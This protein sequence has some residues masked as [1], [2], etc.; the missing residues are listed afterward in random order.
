MVV[1]TLHTGA[2]ESRFGFTASGALGKAVVRN[3]VKRRLREAVRSLPVASGWDIVMNAR[4]KAVQADYHSLHAEL[5][6]LLT[7]ARVLEERAGP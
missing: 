4:P 3:R 6:E 5:S 1:R 7:K 2:P